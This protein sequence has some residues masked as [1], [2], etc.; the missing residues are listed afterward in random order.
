MKSEGIIL[1]SVLGVCALFGVGVGEASTPVVHSVES[2][3]SGI[4]ASSG[5]SSGDSSSPATLKQDLLAHYPTLEIT[6]DALQSLS[7]SPASAPTIF[8]SKQNCYKGATKD[9]TRYGKANVTIDGKTTYVQLASM[10][11][12][13]YLVK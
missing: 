5:N 12:G 13:A 7:C 4:S 9:V 3:V 2:T 11:G 1:A 8:G 10:G 6:D